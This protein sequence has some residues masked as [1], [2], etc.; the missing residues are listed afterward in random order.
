MNLVVHAFSLEKI[1]FANVSVMAGGDVSTTVTFGQ[2][3]GCGLWHAAR[4]RSTFHFSVK[5]VCSLSNAD[6]SLRHLTVQMRQN[7]DALALM[8]LRE[9][10]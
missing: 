3:V 7:I 4:P 1:E 9:K 5:A 8:R 10:S 2:F 6:T